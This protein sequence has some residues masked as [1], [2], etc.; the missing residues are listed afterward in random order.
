V[1]RRDYPKRDVRLCL[2][3][4]SRHDEIQLQ[5]CADCSSGTIAYWGFFWLPEWA[6]KPKPFCILDVL[7]TMLMLTAMTEEMMVTVLGMLIVMVKM[8]E[9]C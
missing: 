6:I 8:L 5:I 2:T 9:Y 1:D 7:T 3:C 4:L